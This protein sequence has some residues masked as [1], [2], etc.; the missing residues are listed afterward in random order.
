VALEQAYYSWATK[1][2]G[3]GNRL[4]VVALSPGLAKAP[5]LAAMPAVKRIC[6]YDFPPRKQSRQPIS[7]GWLDF[8]E[9]RL[10]FCRVA[11]ES[12]TTRVG[13]FSA[14]VLV[15]SRDEL[16][17]GRL[18]L[19]FGSPFWWQGQALVDMYPLRSTG[20]FDLPSVELDDIPMSE[21]QGDAIDA[22]KIDSLLHLL[23]TL[24]RDAK[25][26]IAVDS[27][28]LGEYVRVI[29]KECPIAL[30]GLSISTYEGAPTFPFTVVGDTERRA[31]SRKA[32][33][34]TDDE[35]RDPATA[36]ALARLRLSARDS[37]VLVSAAADGA[38]VSPG[39]DRRH[40]F[41]DRLRA[42]VAVACGL[43]TSRREVVSALD[44]P[45]GASYVASEAPGQRR[46]AEAICADEPGVRESLSRRVSALSDEAL[47]AL[48][49]TTLQHYLMTR[50]FGGCSSVASLLPTQVSDGRGLLGGVLDA[51][52]ASEVG[53]E[54]LFPADLMALL[55]EAGESGVP[56][57]RL[58][59]LLDRATQLGTRIARDGRVPESYVVGIL[60]RL[61]DASPSHDSGL[62]GEILLARPRVLRRISLTGTQQARLVASMELLGG[63]SLEHVLPFAL[64]A[65]I[66][67]AEPD[68]VRGLLRRL[69][70]AGAAR[71]LADTSRSLAESPPAL[72]QLCDEFAA[73]LLSG[74]T[75]LSSLSEPRQMRLTKALLDHS[76]SRD[77]A[78]AAKV[79]GCLLSTRVSYD[80]LA[81]AVRDAQTI[82]DG[83]LRMAL[84]TVSA[85]AALGRVSCA[86]D[87]GLLW[88]TLR[89]GY[90]D[91]VDCLRELLLYTAR[92]PYAATRLYVLAWIGD[93]LLAREPAL[94][95]RTGRLG[96][97]PGQTLCEDLVV[98]LPAAWLTQWST[99]GDRSGRTAQ[100]WWVH[101][102]RHAEKARR[103]AGG[104]KG[105]RERLR[106]D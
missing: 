92:V 3:G 69:P 25:V 55:V 103:N 36:A 2:L 80:E 7:F 14:H 17:E 45:A 47:G 63:R 60:I 70:L 15:G 57:S 16:P 6:R 1:E 22:E 19:L 20:T 88:D 78:V 96:D 30:E 48:C 41:W 11:L 40:M 33:S 8:R 27:W 98:T 93:V 89:E 26:A 101:L 81:L 28:T 97:E 31:G 102:L 9:Y 91:N 84:W 5:M 38:G 90:R 18:A 75:G 56:P 4:Q 51:L 86:R 52:V 35:V 72:S 12:D 100:Q 13:N 74:R 10:G 59:G 34:P 44:T 29:A 76:Q 68:A 87:V 53:V 95:A 62:V 71:L 50:E 94:V 24:P 54:S 43:E 65:V 23:V 79:L 99:V 67:S 32:F 85:E 104:V 66:G 77:G 105:L 61:L 49:D 73:E 64:P 21:P 37:R 83:H 46:L 39:S 58:A 42:I 106:R 82:Q